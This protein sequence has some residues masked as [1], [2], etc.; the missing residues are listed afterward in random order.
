MAQLLYAAVILFHKLHFVP[1]VTEK[2]CF[3]SARLVFT[4]RDQISVMEH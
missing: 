1:M 3:S 4:A 2:C